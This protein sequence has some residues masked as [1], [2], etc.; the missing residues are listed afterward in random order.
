[1]GRK[2]DEKFEF[3]L[4][5][6]V[7]VRLDQEGEV[8]VPLVNHTD[9]EIT[10]SEGCIIGGF[11]EYDDTEFTLMSLSDVSSMMVD[12]AMARIAKGDS[13]LE[14]EALVCP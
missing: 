3:G 6:Q 11:Q 4:A 14:E 10:I 2:D 1:M 7:V 9:E 13:Q 8:C 12:E 5:M